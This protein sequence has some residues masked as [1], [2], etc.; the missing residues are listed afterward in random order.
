MP[1]HAAAVGQSRAEVDTAYQ[2]LILA[3]MRVARA[4]LPGIAF[5]TSIFLFFFYDT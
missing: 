2:V 4:G 3:L 1:Y 5:S